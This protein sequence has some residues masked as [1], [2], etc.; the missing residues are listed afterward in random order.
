MS[1]KLDYKLQNLQR[2]IE[3]LREAVSAVQASD[4]NSILQDGL[5]QRFEFTYELAWKSAKAK[6]EEQGVTETNSPKS[7]F[8]ELYQLKWI[9]DEQ[10]WLELIKDRNLTSHVYDEQVAEEIASRVMN[11]YLLAFEILFHTLV[12]N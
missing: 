9:D 10:I 1:E 8:R 7:V 11:K 12:K 4:P 5:I 2:A 3:R 6:L